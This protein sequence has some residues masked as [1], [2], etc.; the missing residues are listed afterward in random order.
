MPL[1][2]LLEAWGSVFPSIEEYVLESVETIGYL[3]GEI[4]PAKLNNNRKPRR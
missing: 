1:F 2:L 4:A 3:L